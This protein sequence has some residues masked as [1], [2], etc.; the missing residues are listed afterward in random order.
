MTAGGQ[1]SNSE[2]FYVQV[3][4]H[5]QFAAVPGAPGGKGPVTPVTNGNVVNLNGQILA[6]NYCGVYENFAYEFLDQQFNAILNGTGTVTEVFTNVSPLPGP[7]PSVNTVSFATQ[8]DTDTQA[9]GGTYPS[10]CLR[11]NMGT[12][13]TFTTFPA[14]KPAKGSL[15]VRSRDGIRHLT[16]KGRFDG[17]NH[18]GQP[19]GPNHPAGRREMKVFD[20]VRK[21]KV[22]F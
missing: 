20:A 15:L 12:D 1:P 17:C 19:C 18:S 21:E 3:P 13:G 11:G 5:F 6:S 14:R 7:T 10:Y 9:Y 16:G 2:N 8:G 4:T 22:A